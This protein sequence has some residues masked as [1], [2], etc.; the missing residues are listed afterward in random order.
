ML[1]TSNTFAS[2]AISVSVSTDKD[3]YRR[4]DDVIISGVVSSGGSPISGAIVGI[5]VKNPLGG[6]VFVDQKTTG[7]DGK[8]STSF[9]LPS[10]AMIGVYTVSVTATYGSESAI[11]SITFRVKLTS[12]V[13][14]SVSPTSI[15][16]GGSITVSGSISPAVSGAIVTLTF[17]RPDGTTTTITASTGTGGSYSTAYTPD[18]V[19]SWTVYASWAGD[20]TYFGASSSIASFT[21]VKI[22]SS[23]SLSINATS[24]YLGRSIFVE[25]FLRP[26]VS[27]ATVTI[28]YTSPNGTVISKSVTINA[29]GGFRDYFKPD[30]EGVWRIR[31][32]WPGDALRTSASSATFELNVIKKKPSTISCSLSSTSIPAYGNVTI[33]GAISPIRPFT[34]VIIQYGVGGVFHNITVVRTDVNG[35]YRY[36]WSPT[37]IGTYLIRALWVG[38]DEYEG[39]ISSDQTLIVVKGSSS[40][41]ISLRPQYVA[42][43]GN[44]TISGVLHP[45]LSNAPITIMFRAAGGEWSVLSTVNTDLNGIYRYVWV[46]PASGVYQ[47]KS[48]WPGNAN[49]NGAESSIVN[50]TIVA[51]P[52]TI[53]CSISPMK[54]KVGESIR[55]SG[56]INPPISGATVTVEIIKPDGSTLHLTNRTL[57]NGQYSMV[58][59]P[60]IAGSYNVQAFWTGNSTYGGSTSSIISFTVSKASST[61]IIS[62][63]PPSTSIGSMVNVTGYIYPLRFGVEVNV[64][65]V[66][67]SGVRISRV[68]VTSSSGTFWDVIT[69]DE[70]G[71]W[72][73]FAYWLGDASYNGASASKSFTIT[74]KLTT[75]S[76]TISPSIPKVNDTI[77]FSGAI[78]PKV[79]NANVTI[80]VSVD[81][82]MSWSVLANVN[83]N[84]DGKY[85]YSWIPKA[86]GAYMFKSNWPGNLECEGAESSTINVVIAESVQQKSLSLPTG[87]VVNILSASNSTTIDMNIKPEENKVIVNVTGPSKTTGFTSIFIPFS[88][89]EVY[90]TSID[91]MLFLID[92]I[93]VTPIISMIAEGYIVTLRYTHSIHIIELYVV[94]YTLTVKALDYKGLPLPEGAKIV[95]SGPVSL[96]EFT[97]VTGVAVFS[98]LPAGNY[99]V[100]VY[101]GPKVGSSKVSVPKDE[102]VSV[103]TIVGKLEADYEQLTKNY[104]DLQK[105]FQELNSK[106]T[107]LI[108][109]YNSLMTIF[110]ITTIALLIVILVLAIIIYRKKTK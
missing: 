42:A 92:G 78:N 38:D 77:I 24:I 84:V 107:Q 62:V 1:A 86:S 104:N 17:T 2:P 55:I 101:Y 20:D 95:I 46:A 70:I 59:Y 44:I 39:A 40:L 36:V 106:Y 5:I 73:V 100:D 49:L 97:N 16:I 60:D 68:L 67:P 74:K 27:G 63:I 110:T 22:T 58:Y 94:T 103:S 28:E 72:N 50:A 82:G 83:T 4:N 18:Q 9:K 51:Q 90:N 61:I 47:F 65:Y 11:N 99:T 79:S 30:V 109:S 52:T 34:Q 88:L 43:G 105:S 32:T 19:G 12:T 53:S 41:T 33:S 10:D 37:S 29:T 56:A 71:V 31:A 21:V 48:S 6:N 64:T 54:L 75:I 26:I 7:S 45:K 81:G 57:A 35:V 93:P 85:S 69:S 8:Y 23:I 14:C 80:S 15:T 108:S 89:L 66:K 13:S 91:N 102:M 76:L 87:E 25:G 96:Y 98:K 3:A